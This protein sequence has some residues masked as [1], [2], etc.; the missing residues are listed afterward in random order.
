M[1]IRFA[2]VSKVY[3]GEV[4]AVADVSLLIASGECLTVVGPSGG[5]KTTFLRLTAGLEVPSSGEVWH[6]NRIAAGIPPPE[7]NVAMAFQ[8]PALYPH[9]NVRENIAF[10]LLHHPIPV[11]EGTR[12]VSDIAMSLGIEPLLRRMPDE[13]SGGQRQRVALARCLVRQPNVLL[14]DEPLG[15]LDAPLRHSVRATILQRCR[16]RGTTLLWVTHDPAEAVA[17]GDRVLEMRDGRL[18]G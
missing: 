9:L 17:V 4:R 5:G 6:G 16:Q 8:V 2:N 18:M 1:E 14:L 13:L 15:Q 7:R 11:D 10:P 12:L 3:S